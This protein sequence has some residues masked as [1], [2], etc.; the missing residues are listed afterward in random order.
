MTKETVAMKVASHA[1]NITGKFFSE[2]PKEQQ[3]QMVANAT[4]AIVGETDHGKQVAMIR[5]SV[6]KSLG[7]AAKTPIAQPKP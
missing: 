4:S 6:E 3:D 2:L 1:T 5:A 7:I